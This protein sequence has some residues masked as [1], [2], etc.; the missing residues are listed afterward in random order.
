[1]PLATKWSGRLK[2]EA[3]KVS[4]SGERGVVAK[5]AGVSLMGLAV[6]AGLLHLAIA[7]GMEPAWA[8]VISLFCAMQATFLVNGLHVFRGLTLARL[9]HQWL[10][11]MT[12]NG[13]GNFCNYWIFVTLVSTHWPVISA[14]LFGLTV[15]SLTAWV[16]NYTCTRYLVFRAVE[17]VERKVASLRGATSDSPRA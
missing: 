14:P 8:R 5:Y 3:D 16:M 10:G 9:P 6:D 7:L 4:V 1:L 17:T 13:F 11:Y 15:G 12:T 2:L